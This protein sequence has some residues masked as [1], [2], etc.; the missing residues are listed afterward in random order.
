MEYVQEFHENNQTKNKNIVARAAADSR[1]QIMHL[2]NS[3]LH[4]S[5]AF[6]FDSIY[7]GNS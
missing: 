4:Y 2:T 7:P 6:N 3:R 5:I 1:Q